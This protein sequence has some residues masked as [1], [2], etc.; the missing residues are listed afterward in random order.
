MSQ[1]LYIKTVLL[2]ILLSIQ[3]ACKTKRE[4][5][6]QTDPNN[7]ISEELLDTLVISDVLKNADSITKEYRPSRTINYDIINTKLDLRFDW[8]KQEVIGKANLTLVPFF[9]AISTVELDAVGFDI[10]NVKLIPS[11]VNLI[12]CI[13][14]KNY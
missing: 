6:Y 11:Q 12:Y 1:N 14:M 2:L 5:V 13:M 3:T 7:L 4:V 9:K 8:V 10:H